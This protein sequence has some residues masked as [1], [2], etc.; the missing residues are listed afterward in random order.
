MVSCQHRGLASDEMVLGK[1]IVDCIT[2]I[3]DSES[4]GAVPMKRVMNVEG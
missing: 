4:G 2:W 1:T 3:Y